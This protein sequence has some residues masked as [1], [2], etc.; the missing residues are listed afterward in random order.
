MISI[1]YSVGCVQMSSINQT[2]RVLKEDS[3]KTIE[4][5]KKLLDTEMTK[6]KR[7][8]EELNS[9]EEHLTKEHDK[10]LKAKDKKIVD[11]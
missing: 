6:N 11:L 1:Q 4:N 5:Y 2:Y 9:K 7:L 8:I 3:N 10:V